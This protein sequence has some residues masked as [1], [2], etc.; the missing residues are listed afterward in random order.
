MSNTPLYLK[1]QQVI[2]EVL[3]S[4]RIVFQASK[5]CLVWPSLDLLF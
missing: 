3:G 1:S 2:R 5:T 4:G